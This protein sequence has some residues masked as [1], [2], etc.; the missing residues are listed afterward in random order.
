MRTV[1][2]LKVPLALPASISLVTQ[3]VSPG[4]SCR[5]FSR[6]T[7]LCH[8]GTSCYFLIFLAVERI[9]PPITHTHSQTQTHTILSEL[10]GLPPGRNFS[11]IRFPSFFSCQI[12]L[13]VGADGRQRGQIWC[14][15]R[16][17][18][19]CG[20]KG[21]V[22]RSQKEPA[23]QVGIFYLRTCKWTWSLS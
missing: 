10:F 5:D 18:K 17:S 6:V 15:A 21:H 4:S 1:V 20:E 7:S 8:W 2:F 9:P 14:W 11:L 12:Y 13:E 23:L 19:L 22:P 3:T 16:Q